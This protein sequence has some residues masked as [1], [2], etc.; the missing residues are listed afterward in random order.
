MNNLENARRAVERSLTRQLDWRAIVCRVL[1]VVPT[2][3]ILWLAEA[4]M[5]QD[6]TDAEW[7][8]VL[9]SEKQRVEAVQSVIHSVIAIYDADRQGGGSGVIIDPTG[10]AITN[11]HV[12]MGAGVRGWGGLAD[13]KFYEWDLIGTDPGGDVAVIQM[14]GLD[15]FPYSRLADSDRIRVGDWALAMGNPFVLTEDQFPTVTLGIVSG[16]KRYQEGAGQNQLVYGNC[17]QIDSSI[18][19]GNSGGPLFNLA[20]QVMGINGRGSFLD[21]GRVNVG[22]GY[23]ISANQIKNFYPDLLATKLVEHGTLDANFSDQRDQVIC[24]TINEL[25]PVAK[26]GLQLGDRLLEFEGEKITTANQFTNLMCTLPEDWPASLKIEKPDGTQKQITVRLFGLAYARSPRPLQLEKEPKPAEKQKH[27][28]QKAMFEL[29][30]AEPGA[31]RM[32]D[33]NQK[34]ANVLLKKFQATSAT[35]IKSA[36]S[37]P[38][39]AAIQIVDDCWRGNAIMATCTTQILGNGSARVDWQTVD[40]TSTQSFVF[41]GVRFAADNDGK[42]RELTATE[43]KLSPELVQA[44]GQAANRTGSPFEFFGTR[45]IDGSD[46]AQLQTACRFRCLDPDDDWFYFWTSLY[47]RDAEEHVV[48]LK[49]SPDKDCDRKGKGVMFDQWHVQSGWLVAGRRAIISGLNEQIEW[50]LKYRSVEPIADPD[51]TRFEIAKLLESK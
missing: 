24:S 48:L 2:L 21:R 45:S 4:A 23:A 40:G 25:S 5:A 11:H 26:L 47:N 13:G 16:V 20:G 32:P 3:T 42:W 12:I 35:M 27:D 50:E 31:T 38:P 19:P 51:L 14:Q 22:L 8:T 33:I 39:A 1:F 30:D 49:A 7:Q 44:L 10:L 6:L 18:N 28:L 41:D 43:A 36:K 17:I 37:E 29:L 9:A 46:K 15:S 34:N